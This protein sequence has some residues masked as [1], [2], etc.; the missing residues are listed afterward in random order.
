VAEGDL[1]AAGAS[2]LFGATFAVVLGVRR[3]QEAWRWATVG[4]VVLVVGG[5]LFGSLG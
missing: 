4:T 2:A 5:L 3:G 1:C